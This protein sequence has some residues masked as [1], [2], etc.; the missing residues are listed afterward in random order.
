MFTTLFLLSM[1]VASLGSDLRTAKRRATT[2]SQVITECTVPNTVALTFD[3]GPHLYMKEISETLEAANAVGTFFL[4]GNNFACIYD[5]ESVDRVKYAYDKGHQIASHTWSHAHLPTLSKDELTDEFSRV[6]E[7]LQNTI[8]ALPAFM[9]PPFGEYND[10]VVEVA[11]ER[12]QT[13]V[14]WDFDSE[15]SAGKTADESKELYDDI[16]GQHPSTI[17][18]LNHEVYET[19]AND[20]LPYVI[21]K[22]QDAGYKMVSLAD[23][24]GQSAYQSV[25][26][27]GE[28]DSSWQCDDPSPGAN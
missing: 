9:R 2:D 11:G 10:L 7:A 18:T 15:D 14:I 25:D 5:E 23:C 27:P 16:I 20:V 26:S 8:G 6:D 28:R 19:T 1:S 4:N 13:V 21:E 24:L 3:D 12:N 17:L 22:L